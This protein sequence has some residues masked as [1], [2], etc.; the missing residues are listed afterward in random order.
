MGW[1]QVEAQQLL[2][3]VALPDRKRWSVSDST[4]WLV[5]THPDS[6]SELR[7]RHWRA[8]PQTPRSD[9][10]VQLSRWVPDVPRPTELTTVDRRRIELPATF[11]T[12]LVVG[13]EPDGEG[14][15]GWAL[16]IGIAPRRCFAALY[17]TRA[18]GP[19]MAE[20]VADRLGL[21]VRRV[22]PRIELRRIESRI[23]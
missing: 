14:V 5:A 20:D 17:R 2:L 23:P 18:E 15:K 21:V 12:E 19:S 3:N 1:G 6:N 22:L 9:C 4:Q 11:D 10:S 7:V 8:G 16:A 13:V